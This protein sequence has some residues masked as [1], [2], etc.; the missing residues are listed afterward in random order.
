MAFPLWGEEW[1]Y[2]PLNGWKVGESS[3]LEEAG[4]GL[5][6]ALSEHL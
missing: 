5:F 2:V 6:E 4:S 1:V 3:D